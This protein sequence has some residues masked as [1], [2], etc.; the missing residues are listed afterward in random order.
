MIDC[1]T[2]LSNLEKATWDN[3]SMAPD[4]ILAS[5]HTY[6]KKLQETKYNLRSYINRK[7]VAVTPMIVAL[8]HKDTDT[9]YCDIFELKI[10]EFIAEKPLLQDSKGSSSG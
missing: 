4:N 3:A 7:H 6:T 9:Y 5:W 2:F 1:N 10:I 8:A